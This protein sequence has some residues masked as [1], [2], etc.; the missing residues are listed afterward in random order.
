MSRYTNTNTYPSHYDT[1]LQQKP[2]AYGITCCGAYAH[3]YAYGFTGGSCISI[4]SPHPSARGESGMK[5]SSHGEIGPHADEQSQK[6]ASAIRKAS[7]AV[8][9]PRVLAGI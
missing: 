1:I 5:A 7:A 2:N 4:C 6:Q 9:M 3:G 8:S